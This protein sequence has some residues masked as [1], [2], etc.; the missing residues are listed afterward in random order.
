MDR[1]HE[2]GRGA[3]CGFPNLEERGVV[4]PPDRLKADLEAELEKY[5]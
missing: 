3:C 2:R 5:G 4:V 1:G